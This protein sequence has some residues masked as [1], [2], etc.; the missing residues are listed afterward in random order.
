MSNNDSI[1]REAA[2]IEDAVAEALAQ[3]GVRKDDVTVEVQ[4]A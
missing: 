3:L 1:E 2:T 4:D